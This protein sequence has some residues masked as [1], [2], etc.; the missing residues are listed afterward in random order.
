MSDL[1]KHVQIWCLILSLVVMLS[2]CGQPGKDE[3]V[4]IRQAPT[5]APILEQ[6]TCPAQGHARAA[7]L[8]SR[9]AGGHPNLIY[10]SWHPGP[11]YPGG[12]DSVPLISIA[13]GDLLRYDSVTAASTLILQESQIAS[14]NVSPDGQWLLLVS[15]VQRSPVQNRERI[16]LIRIDGQHLQTLYCAPEDAYIGMVLFSPDQHALVFT[17]ASRTGDTYLLDV[18]TGKLH[19]ALSSG[20]SGFPS[21][22]CIHCGILEPVKWATNNSVYFS[23]DSVDELMNGI[24]SLPYGFD[25]YLLHDSNK[26]ASQQQSNLQLI[27]SAT[28]ENQCGDFDITPDNRQLACI[29]DSASRSDTLKMASP[30]GSMFHI[31][32]HDPIGILQARVISNTTLLFIQTHITPR[33][34]GP[35]REEV[36]WKINTDGSQPVKL[37]TSPG[38]AGYWFDFADDRQSWST[39][40]R[41]GS[42]YV[43]TAGGLQ[44]LLIGS[45]N[46]GPT[47]TI[48]M[49]KEATAI[50]AVG[51]TQF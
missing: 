4:S 35:D 44:S 6:Q 41:D 13:G 5:T 42:L 10:R 37:M 17:Q 40:S 9:P 20:R 3:A 25:L 19:L 26:D 32:Y 7:N 27:A 50:T 8:L 28:S 51:W 14:V 36:L 34:N 11:D 12:S 48:S 1:R 22:K 46:G 24:V 39:L 33:E 30:V 43:V 15:A 31:M 38:P 23:N 2:A 21:K 29:V 45:L 18:A 47:K 16:Q 49:P